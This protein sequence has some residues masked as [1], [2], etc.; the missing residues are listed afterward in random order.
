MWRNPLH[1]VGPYLASTWHVPIVAAPTDS[2]G[3]VLTGWHICPH[4]L[5]KCAIRSEPACLAVG[6]GLW[7]GYP[8]QDGVGHVESVG[9]LDLVPRDAEDEQHRVQIGV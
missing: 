3:A 2:P 5:D 7:D 9:R 8:L 4:R 1:L 6:G